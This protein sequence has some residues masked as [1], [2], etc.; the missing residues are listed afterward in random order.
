[1]SEH[2]SKVTFVNTFD[3]VLYFNTVLM[4][5]LLSHLQ[6]SIKVIRKGQCGVPP[7]GKSGKLVPLQNK[8]N[9]FVKPLSNIICLHSAINRNQPIIAPHTVFSLYRQYLN[10]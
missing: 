8:F 7:K 10:M 2:V 6:V 1:M 5:Y 9:E 4:D 3:T